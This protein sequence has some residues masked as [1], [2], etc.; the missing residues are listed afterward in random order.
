MNSNNENKEVKQSTRYQ[1]KW[2]DKKKQNGFKVVSWVI[3][4]AIQTQLNDYR[5]FLMVQFGKRMM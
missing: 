2:L 3:P 1:Y 5:Q 4:E